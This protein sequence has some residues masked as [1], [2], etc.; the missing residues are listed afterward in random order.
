MAEKSVGKGL[1]SG[2]ASERSGP[3]F[4]GSTDG[5]VCGEVMADS[6]SM[7]RIQS[8]D[9]GPRSEWLLVHADTLCRAHR[10]QSAVVT[11]LPVA[12]LCLPRRETSWLSGFPREVV[13]PSVVTTASILT[14]IG[15]KA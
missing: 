5:S 3:S 14:R 2:A 1:A 9:D 7:K 15:R 10:G 8:C 6:I 13:S 11:G 4:V 12:F